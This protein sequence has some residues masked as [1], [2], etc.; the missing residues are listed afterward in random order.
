M[1]SINPYSGE[2]LDEYREFSAIEINDRICKSYGSWNLWKKTTFQEKSELMHRAAAILKERKEALA[3]LITL[4]MGK[5]IGEALAEIEKCAWVCDYYAEQAG[6][7]LADEPI[8]TEAKKSLAIFQP[9]GPVLAIMP[10]NYPFWQTFRFAAPALMAGNTGLLKHA[11]TVQGCAL[12]IEQIFRDAGFPEG[13][14]STLVIGASAVES[15]INHEYVRAVT[16][17]GSE[18]A[19]RMVASI[20]GRN[21]KKTV[22][23]LG[24]SDP[25]LIMADANL[26]QAARIGIRSRMLTSGQTCISA[27]RFIVVKEVAEAFIEQVKL[28]MAQYCFGDPLLP[29]TTLAPLSK[30]EFALDVHRQVTQSVAMGARCLMGGELPAAGCFYPATLLVGVHSEMPVCREETFGPVVAVLVVDHEDQA[31]AEA[32][33]TDFGLGASV[34]TN[35]PETAEKMIRQIEAGAVFV[36][37]LVKSDPRMPFG[38]IKNS[39]YGRELAAYGIK[40]FC[41]IKSVWIES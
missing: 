20:A 24:G 8:E 19:G 38:G 39:G 32:N 37:Q 5:L 27:K 13:V 15:V 36:N 34:W 14:F 41:N 6:G 3:R 31:I 1:K 10:W 23:E 25:C 22:L 17:T 11:S 7:L 33:S 12:A 26:E 29:E 16:L 2:I 9:I 28:V 40:E 4:E 35:N 18:T 30:R 21:L